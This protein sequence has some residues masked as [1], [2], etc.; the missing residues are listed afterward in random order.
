MRHTTK[1]NRAV[2]AY[3]G[4][5]GSAT[6]A[7]VLSTV[8]E[9]LIADVTSRQLAVIMSLRN[10]AY[11]EAKASG[12]EIVDDCAWIPCPTSDDPK[13]GKLIPLA[14]LRSVGVTSTLIRNIVPC[15]CPRHYYDYNELYRN[16]DGTDRI[17]DRMEAY[18]YTGPCWMLERSNRTTY[19]LDTTEI[20]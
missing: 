10:G 17:W 1:I 9:T 7:H 8:P 14:V 19:T 16:Q 4:H 3:S 2:A 15:D 20:L 13:A 18:S 6:V 11:H 5:K 12:I